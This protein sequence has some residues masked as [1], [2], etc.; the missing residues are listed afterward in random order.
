MGHPL[1]RPRLRHSYAADLG[2][3]IKDAIVDAW[4]PGTQADNWGVQQRTL[5]VE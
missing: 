4:L 3:W 5:V 2:S 1:L